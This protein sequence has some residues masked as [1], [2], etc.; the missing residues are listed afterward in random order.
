ML[1]CVCAVHVSLHLPAR[2]LPAGCQHHMP[3]SLSAER[4]PMLAAD[5]D[6]RQTPQMRGA[7]PEAAAL[8]EEQLRAL[9][10]SLAERLTAMK[11]AAYATGFRA[12]KGALMEACK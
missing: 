8:G 6:P 1:G 5:A 7:T 10:R 11:N 3:A 4:L 9:E 12:A 2:V